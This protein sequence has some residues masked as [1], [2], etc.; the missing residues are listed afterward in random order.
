VFSE[1]FARRVQGPIC[2]IED[3]SAV[4]AVGQREA[5]ENASRPYGSS[6]MPEAPGCAVA[7]GEMFRAQAV[8][9][10]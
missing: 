9:V 10:C 5:A 1:K 7:A 2:N 4:G 6:S 3:Q 8:D